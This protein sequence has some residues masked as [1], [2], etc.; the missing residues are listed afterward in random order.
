MTLAEEARRAELASFEEFQELAARVRNWGRWGESDQI[1]ALNLITPEKVR[2]SAELVRAGKVFPLGIRFHADGVWGPS[3]LRRNPIHLFA[4]DGGD[5]SGL[6]DH[7][8][9]WPDVSV[10][11]SIFPHLWKGRTRYADDVVIMSL[12]SSTQWDSLGHVWYDDQ[13]YNGYPAAAVTSRGATRNGIERTL[14]KGVVGR[15]VL[16]DVARHRGVDSL[17]P[18]SPIH[19]DE[20]NEVCEAQGVEVR[21]GDILLVRTGWWSMFGRGVDATTWRTQCP[22]LHWT[23]ATWLREKDVA[24]VAS[25][26]IAVEVSGAT[27]QE[28]MLP[29]HMLTIRDMGVMLGEFWDLDALAADCAEDGRYEV[30]LVAAPLNIPGA[31]GS[32]LNP[33]AMK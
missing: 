2:D 30:H 23:T 18:L 20:L 1:G 19:A 29:L 21:S 11:D 31:V 16:L 9:G 5:S 10:A 7:L 12:Q 26:N 28:A 22:G 24:A 33:I 25:D 8:D 3:G 4:I 17:A 6:G 15:A 27:V 13:L 32:P 14:A